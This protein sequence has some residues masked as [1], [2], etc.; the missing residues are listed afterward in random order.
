M[1]QIKDVC[2]INSDCFLFI[3]TDFHLIFNQ[4]KKLRLHLNLFSDNNFRLTKRN[5]P[6]TLNLPN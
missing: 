6:R 4:V 3:L 5:Q 2:S 1:S